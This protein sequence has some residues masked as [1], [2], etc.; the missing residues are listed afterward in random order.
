MILKKS[1]PFLVYRKLCSDTGCPHLC[2]LA[3]RF[4]L[5]VSSALQA[6]VVC[7]PCSKTLLLLLLS[8]VAIMHQPQHSATSFCMYATMIE[9]F[10]RWPPYMPCVRACCCHTRACGAMRLGDGMGL[11]IQFDV[12]IIIESQSQ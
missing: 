7:L 12:I 9:I 3:S 2:Y 11:R 6:A 1:A 5:S 8:S 10:M 4:V